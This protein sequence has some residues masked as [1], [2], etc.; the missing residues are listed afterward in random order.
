[1]A[2]FQFHCIFQELEY[3]EVLFF[4]FDYSYQFHF[5][6]IVLFYI[7][8]LCKLEYILPGANF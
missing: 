6:Q 2:Q 4:V 3:D 5:F 8:D 1:M 7:G